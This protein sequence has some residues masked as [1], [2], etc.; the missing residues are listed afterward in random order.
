M[1]SN[2]G[3]ID[4]VLRIATAGIL[5]G[6][7]ATNTIGWRGWVVAIIP[8]STGLIGWCPIYS[9]AGLSTVKNK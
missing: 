5:A 4:K 7:A 8:L 9:A 6:L 2:V 1:K 3:T